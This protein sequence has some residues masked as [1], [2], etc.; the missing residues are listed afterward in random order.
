MKKIGCL[1]LI[2]LLILAGLSFYLYR[3]IETPLDSPP[4]KTLEI[5]IKPG[6]SAVS[7]AEQLQLKGLI[8]SALIFRI[9]LKI[10]SQETRLKSGYYRLS[11]THSV[12]EITRQLVEEGIYSRMVTF[13]EGFTAKQMGIVLQ[14]SGAMKT[15]AFTKAAGKLVFPIGNHYYHGAEGFL[16]PDTYQIDRSVTPNRMVEIMVEQFKKQI[17]P[18]YLEARQKNP[19]LLPLKQIIILASLI[20]REAAVDEERP[21][22]AG[23]YYNRLKIAMP[24]QCDATIQ[25]ALGKIKPELSLQDLKINSPYNTYLHPGLPPGAIGNPGKAAILAALYPQKNDYLYYVLNY[26]KNDGSHIFNRTYQQH[27]NTINN[28][29]R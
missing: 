6:S 24:L 8:K 25:Y 1:G 26:D 17:Y 14:D 18:L 19:R 13:P 5:D 4:G 23:V 15:E 2:I 16:L 11:S 28:F 3:Q 20:E 29:R 7:I 12:I 22:I 27:L 9:W 21:I 10:S